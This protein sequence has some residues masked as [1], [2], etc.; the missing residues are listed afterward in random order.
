MNAEKRLVLERSAQPP[1]ITHL[2]NGDY[3]VWI[4]FALNFEAGTYLRLTP[5]GEV[6][7]ETLEPT[8][9]VRSSVL[10]AEL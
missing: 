7:R 1:V 4:H 10:V 8:G 2:P 6:F 9:E 5:Y 3:I